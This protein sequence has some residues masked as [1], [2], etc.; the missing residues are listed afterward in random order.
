MVFSVAERSNCSAAFILHQCSGDHILPGTAGEDALLACRCCSETLTPWR[1]SRRRWC[2]RFPTEVTQKKKHFHSSAPR[3]LV[4][5]FWMFVP[6][7]SLNCCSAVTLVIS[8]PS[9]WSSAGT[10]GPSVPTSAGS[11]ALTGSH[12]ILLLLSASMTRSVS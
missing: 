7:C 11:S 12:V 9:S 5:H 8:A 3:L 1:L 6:T 4:C 10:C 2:E